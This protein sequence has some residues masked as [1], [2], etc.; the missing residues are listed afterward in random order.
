M[1]KREQIRRYVKGSPDLVR[2]RKVQKVEA[3]RGRGGKVVYVK[4]ESESYPF[5]VHPNFLQELRDNP[6]PGVEPRG[7]LNFNTGYTEYPLN[8]SPGG[9][10]ER[11]ACDMKVEDIGALEALL[12]RVGATTPEVPP[13]QADIEE[14]R[15]SLDTLQPTAREAVVMA[16]RG[17]GKFR[18]DLSAIWHGQCAVTGCS[19]E[20]L[21][22]ASHIKPWR[23]S[24][25]RERL[26]RYNGLLL[27][28]NLD[29]AFDACLI[30]FKED[31]TMLFDVAL[32]DEPWKVLGIA[33]AS[34]LRGALSPDQRNYL[35]HHR[36]AS[37]LS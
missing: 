24:D 37:G 19:I 16:R 30:S 5:A 36:E 11:S 32:G 2:L 26:D 25:N 20:A 10:Q 12:V 35:Q 8:N 27:V 34:S 15:E 6:I 31:G 1:L 22:R 17:Q 3:F 4:E 28:A 18:K 23:I 9:N 29:A 21:L 33:P 7:T 13:E 14:A